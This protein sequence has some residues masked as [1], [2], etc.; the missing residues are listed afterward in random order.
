MKKILSI[1]CTIA[2]LLVTVL[3]PSSMIAYAD[4]VPTSVIK[5]Y[6]IDATAYPWG[7]LNSIQ[8]TFDVPKDCSGS[9]GYISFR[10]TDAS[11]T[12][13]EIT[14]YTANKTSNSY[15]IPYNTPGNVIQI[16]LEN[17]GLTDADLSNVTGFQ[18]D[19][20]YNGDNYMMWGYGIT[21]PKAAIPTDTIA[22]SKASGTIYREGN[23]MGDYANTVVEETFGVDRTT[24][25]APRIYRLTE[26]IYAWYIISR[27][28]PVGYVHIVWNDRNRHEKR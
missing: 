2:I 17:L 21:V 7:E 19:L 20:Y 22:A 26:E 1:L 18:V 8:Q 9:E 10:R 6:A 28:Q 11:T 5:E 3:V 13:Q 16:P 24:T 15:F 14:I 27:R 4:A 23:W 12:A 25:I